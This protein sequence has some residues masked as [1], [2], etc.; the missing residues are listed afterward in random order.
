MVR[1]VK[2][3]EQNWARQGRRELESARKALSAEDHYL[4]AYLSHQAVEKLLKA[5]ILHIHLEP[6]PHTHSLLRLGALAKVPVE[7]EGKLRELTPHYMLSR[8]P[9]A[10]G[11]PP[12]ELYTREKAQSI[13]KDATEVIGWIEKQ[14]KQ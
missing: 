7:H 14:L 4:V 13:L 1:G 12:Y 3:Q 9:D 2:E 5:L 10:S 6:P 11:E 8:Y